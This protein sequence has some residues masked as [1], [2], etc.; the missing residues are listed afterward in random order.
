MI[1]F[2]AVL[3]FGTVA[4]QYS[5]FR[6]KTMKSMLPLFILSFVAL[7]GLGC[8]SEPPT[9]PEA[10]RVLVEDAAASM[11]G[12]PALDAVKTQEIR[13]AGTDWE[14]LQAVEPTAE[15]RQVNTF[16]QVLLLDFDRRRFSLTFDASRTYPT[17]A[18][19]KFVEVIDGDTGMLETT[20]ADGKAVNERLHPSRFAARLRDYNRLPIRVLYTAKAAADL[21]RAEDINDGNRTIHVLKY[22]DNGSPV[23]LHLDSFNKL[24]IRVIYKEDDPI[25]GDTLNEMAFS[26]WRDRSGVRLPDAQSTFLNGKKIREERVRNLINNAKIDE[27]ALTIPAVIRSQPENGQRIISQ[28]TLRRIVMGVTYADFGREQRVELAQVAPGVHHIRGGSHHSMVVEMKDH[29]LVVEAPLFDERSVAVMKALEDKFPGKPVKYLATT[30]FHIDHTGGLRAYAA[31]G[32][33]LLV[34]ESIVPFVTE[35]LERPHTVRPDTLAKGSLTG[36][37]EGVKDTKV[38]TDGER[39]VE[40][41]PIEND[42]AKGMLVAYLAK[43]KIIFVSD[44]YSPP[45]PVPN[46]SVIFERNRATAFYN[47][48]TKA[49]LAVD[50]IVGGHGVAGSFR[51]FEK[52]VRSGS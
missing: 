1:F 7:F 44:L 38:L 23:E 8:S 30:H 12:W 4:P 42:H 14:P 49:G 43:E 33:T 27:P 29:L 19:V 22:T 9:G 10:G 16:A 50:T 47:A 34:H 11:G 20:G 26:D 3:S 2:M 31:K 13:T 24:P 40:L 35:M 46:P 6:E 21:T 37:I 32:A 36:T 15:P 51:D 18:S 48:V 5:R 17:S 41:R 45:G 39:T 25:Y 52:A 28:W